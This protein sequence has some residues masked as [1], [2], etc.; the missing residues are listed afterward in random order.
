M[1]Q[2]TNN[3]NVQRPQTV[4]RLSAFNIIPK[5]DEDE[6]KRAFEAQQEMI[7]RKKQRDETK[8]PAL[9]L[10]SL[11]D[12]FTNILTYLIMTFSSSP[13]QIQVS[14]DLQV[15]VS[16]AQL[17]LE[18]LVPVTVTRKGIMVNNEPV[19]AIDNWVPQDAAAGDNKMVIPGLRAAMEAAAE[20]ERQMAEL[21]PNRPPFEGKMLFIADKEMPSELLIKVLYSAGQAGFASYKFTVVK[22]G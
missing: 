12:I 18:E 4:S 10:N 13:I 14:D 6:A 11:M 16:N 17:G 8:P 5:A 22:G 7:K 21:N 19:M 15:P 9:N 2:P 20:K 3:P 1:N